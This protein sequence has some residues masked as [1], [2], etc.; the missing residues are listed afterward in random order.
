MDVHNLLA[1]LGLNARNR[2]ASLA[3]LAGPAITYLAV[4]ALWNYSSAARPNDSIYRSPRLSLQPKDH[5]TLPYPPDALPGA[6]DVDTPYG[7]IR[8]Y[9]W[10]PETGRKVLFVHGISTP[11]IAFAGLAQKLVDEQGCHVMLFD[12]FGRGYSDVPDPDLYPQNIQL[13]TAQIF[14]VLA[15]SE[16]SWA[17]GKE[18][19]AILG[20][21]LGGGIAASFTSYFPDLVRSLIL[22]AP[23]GLLRDSRIHWTSKFIYGGL[24]PRFLIDRIVT[25]R[26]VS[27]TPSSPQLPE[28]GEQASATSAGEIAASEAPHLAVMANSTA[29]LFADRPGV[30]AA[31]AVDW[32]VAAHPGFLASFI[33]SIKYSPTRN[34]H[35]RWRLIATRREYLDEQKVLIILGKTDSVIVPEETAQDATEALGAA[36]V[37]VKML[38][39]GHDVPIVN[40]EG[41]ANALREFWQ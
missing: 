15:S 12:L 11:C 21:S 36:N 5:P 29:P 16:S 32:Q 35:A 28:S 2:R 34:Q 33:S 37:T 18:R 20:Y 24:L 23:S 31:H 4:R 41:C 9:E 30:S 40:A 22:V 19:F 26:L 8:V 1:R 39:G 14:C 25:G 7:D 27:S 6:R 13:W 10:G 38:D 3:L 17:G